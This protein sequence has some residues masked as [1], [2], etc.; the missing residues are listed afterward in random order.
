MEKDGRDQGVG[1]GQRDCSRI[2][3]GTERKPAVLIPEETT[4]RMSNQWRDR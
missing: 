4:G 1:D 3:G 2:E